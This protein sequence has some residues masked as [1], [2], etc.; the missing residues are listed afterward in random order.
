MATL[1]Y[2]DDSHGFLAGWVLFSTLVSPHCTFSLFFGV[3]V[4]ALSTI[5]NCVT[6]ALYFIRRWTQASSQNRREVMNVL[7]HRL[8]SALVIVGL[9]FFLAK[10]ADDIDM[11]PRARQTLGYDPQHITVVIVRYRCSDCARIHIRERDR[12][13]ISGRLPLRP[14]LLRPWL[15]GPCA[16]EHPRCK[17]YSE[18]IWQ[19]RDVHGRSKGCMHIP[20]RRVQRNFFFSFFLGGALQLR[21]ASPQVIPIPQMQAKCLCDVLPFQFLRLR[22]ERKM[23]DFRRT[24]KSLREACSS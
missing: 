16:S 18:A 5:K 4:A 22:K 24:V 11:S 19:K 12:S 6:I 8:L 23:L 13:D 17:A 21:D 2:P 9:F 20:L 7:I 1:G 15:R 3:W 14:A 10:I